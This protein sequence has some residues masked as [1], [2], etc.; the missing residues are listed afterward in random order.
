M[1]VKGS[2]KEGYKVFIKDKYGE[3]LLSGSNRKK[4]VDAKKEMKSFMKSHDKC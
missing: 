2:P 1:K 4:L 3:T